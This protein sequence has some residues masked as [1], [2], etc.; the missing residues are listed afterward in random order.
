MRL[1]NGL[2]WQALSQRESLDLFFRLLVVITLCAGFYRTVYRGMYYVSTTR[3]TLTTKQM[4]MTRTN[5]K[6]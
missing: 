3:P 1:A 6:H 4:S 5:A 2:N